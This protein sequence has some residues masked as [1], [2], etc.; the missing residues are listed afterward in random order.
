M[1]HIEKERERER[2][3]AR[4]KRERERERQREAERVGEKRYSATR[5]R[6]ALRSSGAYFSRMASTRVRPNWS[7][8]GR[9]NEPRPALHSK[10]RTK[11][12]F[13]RMY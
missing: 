7:F 13:Y 3:G 10:W 12:P 8:F 5:I 11:S 4:K 9:T 6:H 2:E 1:K